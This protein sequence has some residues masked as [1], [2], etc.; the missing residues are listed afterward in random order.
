MT[1]AQEILDNPVSGKL[2]AI[3]KSDTVPLSPTPQK[4]WV[5]VAADLVVK[6]VDGDTITFK[7]ALGWMNTPNVRYVMAA[8]TATDLVGLS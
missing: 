6:L 1:T 4:I 5:G 2:F 8:T 3:T 7:A